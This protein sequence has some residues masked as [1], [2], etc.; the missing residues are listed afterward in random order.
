MPIWFN[1]PR[2]KDSNVFLIRGNRVCCNTMY[3]ARRKWATWMKSLSYITMSICKKKLS[4]LVKHLHLCCEY[5]QKWLI[6][7]KHAALN[8]EFSLWTSHLNG[9]LLDFPLLDQNIT[10][11]FMMSYTNQQR[12]HNELCWTSK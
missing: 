6:M 8:L 10:T 1:L 12:E 3:L 4:D 9:K 7:I 5:E 11:S 2:F